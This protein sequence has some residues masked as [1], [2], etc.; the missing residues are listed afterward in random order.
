MKVIQMLG[1]YYIAKHDLSMHSDRTWEVQSRTKL[2]LDDG[3][4][5]SYVSCFVSLKSCNVLYSL[6]VSAVC[7][8]IHCEGKIKTFE[9]SYG[10]SGAICVGSV[11]HVLSDRLHVLYMYIGCLI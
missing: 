9:D 4:F 7:S 5:V 6:K 8:K 11:V 2:Q 10:R 1:S 3:K